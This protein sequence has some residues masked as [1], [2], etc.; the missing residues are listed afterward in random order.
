MVLFV[1]VCLSAQARAEPWKAY[2]GGTGTRWTVSHGINGHTEDCRTRACDQDDWQRG[3]LDSSIGYRVGADRSWA[4]TERIRLI[5]GA[6]LAAV[7]TEYNLSQRDIL[8]VIPSLTAGLETRNARFSMGA[9][10]GIG[11]AFTDDGRSQPSLSLELRLDAAAE[12]VPGGLRFNVRKSRI[13]DAEL[14]ELGILLTLAGSSDAHW[15]RWDVEFAFGVS[16]PGDGPGR[17]LS[18]DQGIV[19]RFG[20]HRRIG[21]GPA[22]IGVTFAAT[23][24]ESRLRSNF[25][26]TD[27][28]RRGKTI[29][30]A[31]IVWDR[32]FDVGEAAIRIGG[33]AEIADWSDPH[34]LLVHRSSAI[35]P[36]VDGAAVAGAGA[37]FPLGERLGVVVGV[38]QL[39]WF[40]SRLGERRMRLGLALKP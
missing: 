13:G 1:F 31:G 32:R 18:L 33:G 34:R 12:I 40:T 39:Y 26:G 24:H 37:T 27:G 30:S 14:R 11:G 19:Q 16:L 4:G 8:V 28:N 9:L 35:E 15:E 36:G 2:F 29:G 23:A 22:R 17:S 3:N 6:D 38:E 21:D 7:T 5:A 20:F 10:A 25:I